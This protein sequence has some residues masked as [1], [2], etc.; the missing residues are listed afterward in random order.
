M[1]LEV[2]FLVFSVLVSSINDVKHEPKKR[3]QFRFKRVLCGLG[4][5]GV[6]LVGAVMIFKDEGKHECEDATGEHSK[7]S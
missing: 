1:T 2:A 4:L 7:S 6:S 5:S 3:I